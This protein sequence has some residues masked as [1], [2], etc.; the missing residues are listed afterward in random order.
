[1]IFSKQ[2]DRKYFIALAMSAAAI[3]CSTHASADGTIAYRGLTSGID[4]NWSANT[5]GNSYTT[6]QTDSS[7]GFARIQFDSA[8]DYGLNHKLAERDRS[9]IYVK[10]WCRQNGGVAHGPKHFKIFGQGYPNSYSNTTFGL[11][12]Y[13]TDYGVYYGDSAS[14]SN[15]AGVEWSFKGVTTGGTTLSR[16]A[17]TVVTKVSTVPTI[18]NSWHE[19]GYYIKFNDDNTPNGEIIV[20]Y[21]GKEIF[22]LK[23]VYNRANGESPIDNFGIG[24]FYQPIGGSYSMSRDYRDIRVA[25]D[26]WPASTDIKGNFVNGTKPMAPSAVSLQ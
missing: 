2:S 4:S 11:A 18:D 26:G 25:Y 5:S 9:A 23:N 6:W 24:Q 7:T 16:A 3:F 20:Q 21:D 15:D 1:V 10:M 12:G 14:G 13:G 8:H 22:H 17:P 19:W